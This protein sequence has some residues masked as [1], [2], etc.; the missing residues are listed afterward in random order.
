M[1]NLLVKLEIT[2]DHFRRGDLKSV[3]NDPIGIALKEALNLSVPKDSWAV[4]DTEVFLSKGKSEHYIAEYDIKG[5][6]LSKNRLNVITLSFYPV[7]R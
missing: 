1:C 3:M 7:R 2:Q 4:G 6:Y 5:Y